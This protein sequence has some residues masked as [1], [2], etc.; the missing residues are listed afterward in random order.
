MKIR[1]TL[2]NIIALGTMA[3]GLITTYAPN[4]TLLSPKIGAQL[5]AVGGVIALVTKGLASFNH[6]QIPEAKKIE[7]GPVILEK[8]GPIKPIDSTI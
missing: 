3:T 2:G 1:F 8:T 6:E 5:I 7:V 4:I